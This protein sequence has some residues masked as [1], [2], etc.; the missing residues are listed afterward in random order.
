LRA[1]DQS[2]T[3]AAE[4]TLRAELLPRFGGRKASLAIDGT[5]NTDPPD[6][7]ES[8]RRGGEPPHQ[9]HSRL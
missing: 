4:L 1:F 2:I 6:H 3:R 7:Q 9:L 8:C 5:G